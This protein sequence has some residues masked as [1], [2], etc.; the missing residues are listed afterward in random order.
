MYASD[1]GLIF[2]GSLVVFSTPF[3]TIE[4]GGGVLTGGFANLEGGFAGTDTLG[5]LLLSS[6]IL[7]IY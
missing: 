3:D 2:A 5:L 7:S 4:G 1:T 6:L